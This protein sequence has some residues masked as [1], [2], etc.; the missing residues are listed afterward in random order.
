MKV[1]IIVIRNA[2]IPLKIGN[3]GV[4]ELSASS[5]LKVFEI[6]FLYNNINLYILCVLKIL[7]N[8]CE[9]SVK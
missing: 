6:L 5:F 2:Q 8:M 4:F 7:D 3:G 1:M 9:N